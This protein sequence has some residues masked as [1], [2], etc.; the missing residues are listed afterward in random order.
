MPEKYLYAV[1]EAVEATAISR[2]TLYKLVAQGKLT[3]TKLGRRTYFHRRDL[4]RL[5]NELR[6]EG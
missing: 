5:S 6:G 3:K 4:R 2:R 1:E